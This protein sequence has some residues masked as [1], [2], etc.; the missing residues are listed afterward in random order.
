MASQLLSVIDIPDDVV[1][2]IGH[3]QVE[4]EA[5]PRPVA[6]VYVEHQ[7]DDGSWARYESE[8][9]PTGDWDAIRRVPMGVVL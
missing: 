4:A 7:S 5:D 3:L 8:R 1:R 2:A 9:T 6:S